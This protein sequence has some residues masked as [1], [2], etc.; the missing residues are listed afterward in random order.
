MKNSKERKDYF[1]I[2]RVCK[3]L[4]DKSDEHTEVTGQTVS[5]LGRSL[6][7]KFFNAKEKNTKEGR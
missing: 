2:F 5:D 7:E 3:E 6:M 1:I 4:K